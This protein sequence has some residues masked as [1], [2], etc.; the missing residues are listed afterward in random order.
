M[1]LVTM[2]EMLLA[3]RREKRA[4]GA[5]NIANYET[6][7]AVLMAA[8]REKQPVIIQL[9]MRLFDSEKAYDLAGMLIRL[10][11]RASVPVAIH[12]DHGN[13]IKQVKDALAWGYTSVMYDGSRL[14]FEENVKNTAFCVQYA[15]SFGA[16]VEGEIGHVAQGD[17]TAI[18]EVSE[19][20]EFASAT[21]VDALAV[22]I[23]TAHGY[24]TSEPKLDI[25]RCKAIAEALP[26]LPLVL[27][28]GSGTPLA[29]VRKVIENGVAKVNIATEF[30]DTYLKSSRSE[31]EKLNGK[32]LPIDKYFDPI[33]D[34]CAAHAARLMRF[35]AGM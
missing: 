2:K 12:L 1:A 16:S 30:M 33:V 14:P 26:E 34:E 22:S 11:N 23:G 17:E 7:R 3:A 35:F 20:V 25:E 15:H 27:H 28:G 32:F 21:K 9:Y 24:Y 31:L 18:T 29:D 10:A 8:E 4:V 19:A 13:T 5:F 6:A